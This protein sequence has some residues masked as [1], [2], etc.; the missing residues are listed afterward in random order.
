MAIAID[1]KNLS[2]ERRKEIFGVLHRFADHAKVCDT[3]NV[4]TGRHCEVGFHI[5]H[6]LTKFNEVKPV[7]ENWNPTA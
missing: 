5:L 1:L 7:P 6:E 3:C 2:D 4:K